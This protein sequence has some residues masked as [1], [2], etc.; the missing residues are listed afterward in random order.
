VPSDWNEEF[1]KLVRQGI[2]DA[3][4]EPGQETS[5]ATRAP[6]EAPAAS[7]AAS[8]GPG[9]DQAAAARR[10]SIAATLV[11]LGFL[12]ADRA[13]PDNPAVAVLAELLP[14][15]TEVELC[16]TCQKFTCSSPYE[17]VHTTGRF[18]DPGTMRRGRAGERLVQGPRRELVVCTRD[19]VCWTQSRARSQGQDSVT[20]YSVAFSDVLG[21]TV[22]DRHK[23][24]V[25]VYIDEGPTVSF[26][27]DGDVADELQA[28]IDQAAQSN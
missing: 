6:A 23:G 21:A 7:D 16:L 17:F 10:A 14:L 24:V 27:V 4:P 8:A 2:G 22:R 12:P 9:S 5:Q 3:A 28:Q 15:E 11:R 25:E 18:P 1:T 19:A 26:R 13:T 20:L